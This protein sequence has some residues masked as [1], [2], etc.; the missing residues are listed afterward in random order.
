MKIFLKTP[1]SCLIKS[2]DNEFELDTNDMAEI[3]DEKIIY[4]YPQNQNIIPFYINTQNLK[5]CT[6]YSVVIQNEKKYIILEKNANFSSKFKKKLYISGKNCEISIKDNIL[7]FETQNK[8]IQ[9]FVPSNFNEYSTTK[10]GNFACAIFDN[11]L[12]AFSIKEEKIYHFNGQISIDGNQICVTKD[13]NDSVN[14]K[15]MSVFRLNES[16]ELVSEEFDVSTNKVFGELLP[17]RLL[18]S[19]KAKDYTYATTCLSETLKNNIDISQMKDFFGNV[20]DFLPIST[21]E[22]ILIDKNNKKYASFYIKDNEIDDITID[23]L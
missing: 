21:A 7:S 18:E 12:Y 22:F 5:D 6:R 1:Y 10:I 11:D 15:K 17:Y 19:V 8:S 14:R 2:N 9:C 4:V 23:N 20:T 3:I 16:I 13:F